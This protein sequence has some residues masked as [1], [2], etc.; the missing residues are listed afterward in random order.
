[1]NINSI[2][3]YIFIDITINSIHTYIHTYT[4]IYIY[5]CMRVYIYIRKARI[6]SRAQGRPRGAA[7]G[8]ARAALYY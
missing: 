6:C 4:Y 3:K 2:Y 1:M 5:M 8:G 7:G